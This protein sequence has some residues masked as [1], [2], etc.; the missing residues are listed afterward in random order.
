MEEEEEDEDEVIGRVGEGLA[1][2]ACRGVQPSAN[3]NVG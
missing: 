2:G 1:R 3:I